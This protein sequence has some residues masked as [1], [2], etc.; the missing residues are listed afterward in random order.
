MNVMLDGLLQQESLGLPVFF[1]HRDE[2]LLE[3]RVD[4]RTDLDRRPVSH[5]GPRDSVLDPLPG[6]SGQ[7]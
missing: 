6:M 2:F 5:G 1:R 3:L 7:I 4:C